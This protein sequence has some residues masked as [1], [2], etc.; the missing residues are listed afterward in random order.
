VAQTAQQ[1]AHDRDAASARRCPSCGWIQSMRE[2]PA[3][4]AVPHAAMVYEYTVRMADG[5]SSVFRQELAGW[6]LGERLVLI[7]GT[8][9]LD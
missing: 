7:A 5:S 6:R 9:P 3:E 2:I 1:G 8:S 4:V